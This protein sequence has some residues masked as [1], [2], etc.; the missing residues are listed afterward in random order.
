MGLCLAASR[1]N[2]SLVTGRSQLSL[3]EEGS[4]GRR[5]R[6]CTSQRSC[7]YGKRRRKGTSWG[8]QHDYP[9]YLCFITHH[10]TLHVR[11]Y[12]NLYGAEASIREQAEEQRGKGERPASRLWVACQIELDILCLFLAVLCSGTRYVNTPVSLPPPYSQDGNEEDRRGKFK[13]SRR[14]YYVA[15]GD[16]MA[17]N[18]GDAVRN[19]GP[20]PGRWT[21]GG[22]I[23]DHPPFLRWAVD[24]PHMR[25]DVH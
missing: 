21:W 20:G 18:L 22:G 15:K 8:E 17:Q 19:P 7:S 12:I 5:P 11:A 24:E 14:T 6:E 4:V 16:L 3:S 10:Y 1:G 2:R 23:G 25:N 13:R 9:S